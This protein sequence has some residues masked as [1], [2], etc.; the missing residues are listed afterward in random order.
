MTMI[1]KMDIKKVI[2]RVI[3][4]LIKKNKKNI[5]N[6]IE[7]LFINNLNEV[8]IINYLILYNK[9][10]VYISRLILILIFII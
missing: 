5:K 3:S 6:K 7:R 1:I 10:F 2:E 9:D 8:F 4:N